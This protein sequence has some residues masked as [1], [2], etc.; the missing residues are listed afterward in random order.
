LAASAVISPLPGKG[1]AAV[2]FVMPGIIFD[3]DRVRIDLAPGTQ[4]KAKSG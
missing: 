1:E 2:L 3:L 4:I